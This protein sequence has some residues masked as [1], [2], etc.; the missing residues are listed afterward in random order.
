MKPTSIMI[1][2]NNPDLR[3]IL[4]HAFEDR[5][6]LTWTCPGPEIAV[7]I[8]IAVQPAVVI[9]DL[10]FLGSDV[11]RLI[12]AW[13]ELSPQTRVIVE[14]TKTDSGEMRAV[15]AHG[16]HAFLSKPFKL[17]PLFELLEKDIPPC[18]PVTEAVKKAAA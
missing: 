14:S 9:L 10:D 2:E 18:P 15:M 6:Y 11:L 1:V 13:R 4:R 17:P 12:D 3:N 16:A 7:C 5:G 8:F